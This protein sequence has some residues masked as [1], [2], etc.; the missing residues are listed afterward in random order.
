M[1]VKG[2]VDF[3]ENTAGAEGNVALYIVW[4]NTSYWY[5]Q[6]IKNFEGTDLTDWTWEGITGSVANAGTMQQGTHTLIARGTAANG[7]IKDEKHVFTIDNTP[8]VTIAA[9]PA[10]GN[11][12]VKGTVDFKENTAG[13][14]GNVALYIV[15][16]NTSYWY[17]QGIKNFEGT[18]LTDWTWEG[19]TGSVANAGTMQQGTHTLIARGTAANGA[20]KDEKHVFTI[21]N[22]PEVTI[23]GSKCYPDNTFD[24][25]GTTTFKENSAGNEGTVALYIKEI[26]ASSYTKHGATKTYEGKK[27]SWKYSDFTS[28]R[29]QKSVWGQKEILVK[30]VATAANGASASV[31]KG[32]VIPALGCPT[33]FGN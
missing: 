10:D 20:F 28:A 12:D 32:M 24:I 31:V 21:D 33:T 6:G 3:K 9:G 8:E 1:D 5:R 15:W 23:L 27:I 18:D 11:M 4:E 19:I 16:E 25:L 26:S 17:R 30:V 13:A 14:E 7:T 22:T 29:M 2:T